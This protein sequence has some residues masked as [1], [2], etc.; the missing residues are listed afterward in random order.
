MIGRSLGVVTLLAFLAGASSFEAAGQTAGGV[1]ADRSAALRRGDAPAVDAIAK[2]RPVLETAPG[3]EVAPTS[4]PLHPWSGGVSWTLEDPSA[5]RQKVVARKLAMEELQVPFDPDTGELTT[6]GRVIVKFADSTGI[7]V[8]NGILPFPISTTGADLT[9]LEWILTG[10]GATARQWIDRDASELATLS[11]RAFRASGRPQPDL[12]TILAIEPSLDSLAMVAQSLNKLDIVEWVEIERTM[13]QAQECPGCGVCDWPCNL[14]SGPTCA[15]NPLG[16]LCQVVQ[17]PECRHGCADALCCN[18]VAAILPACDDPAQPRGWDQL[19]AALANVLCEGTLYDTLNPGLDFPDRYD[20]CLGVVD[21]QGAYVPNP[22]FDPFRELLSGDCFTVRP[23]TIGGSGPWGRGCNQP[24]CCR[25]VCELDPGCCVL[26]WD[27]LCVQIAMQTEPCVLD[28]S[29]KSSANFRPTPNYAAELVLVPENTVFG[30]RNVERARGLQAYTVGA[31]VI[32]WE[33]F[34]ELPPIPSSPEDPLGFLRSGFRGWGLDLPQMRA[35]ASL[36]PPVSGTTGLLLDG[37][38]VRV[39]ILDV[40]FD[41]LHEDFI[42]REQDSGDPFGRCIDPY[43]IPRVILEPGV[44]QLNVLDQ[45]RGHGTAVA[46]MILAG[47]NGFGVTGIASRAQGY[48]FPIASQE[49]GF[50]FQNAFFSMLQEF[51]AGDVAVFP[52]ALAPNGTVGPFARSSQP[53]VTSPAY[54]TLVRIASDLNILCVVSAGNSCAPV[55]EEAAGEPPIRSGALVVGAGYPGA[56]LEVAPAG[57]CIGLGTPGSFSRVVYSNWHGADSAIA[58]VDLFGWGAA[59]ATTGGLPNLFRGV[60][61]EGSPWSR[62]YTNSFGGTSAAAALVAGGAAVLQA[63]GRQTYG[64][65]LRPESIGGLMRDNG[66]PQAGRGY[67]NLFGFPGSDVDCFPDWNLGD[68]VRRIGAGD[69]NRG[70][71]PQLVP[72]AQSLISTG[73]ACALVGLDPTEIAAPIDG[74]EEVEVTVSLTGGNFDGI[75]CGWTATA[76]DSWIVVTVGS[77]TG[78]EGE[79]IVV[80]DVLPNDTDEVRVGEVLIAA[81]SQIGVVTV[82]QAACQL[83]GAVPQEFASNADGGEDLEIAVLMNGQACP[84]TATTAAPWISITVGSGTGAPDGNRVIFDILPNDTTDEREGL[85]LLAGGGG[86]PIEIQVVQTP[87]ASLVA[88]EEDEFQILPSGEVDRTALVI[89]SVGF[90]P[91]VATTQSLWIVITTSAGTGEPGGDQLVF[92]VLPNLTGADRDGTIIV[93]SGAT[94]IEVAVVQAPVDS[95]VVGYTI[96]TGAELTPPDPDRI[97]GIDEIAIDIAAANF[98]GGAPV[99]GLQYI[100]TGWVTDIEVEV[101]YDGFNPGLPGGNVIGLLITNVVSVSIPN[102]IGIAYAFNR[103]TETWDFIA[104]QNPLPQQLQQIGYPL[105]FGS[106]GAYVD[107]LTGL[108]RVRLWTL[109]FSGSIYLVRHDFIN[110]GQNLFLPVP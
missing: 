77:G 55:A 54:Y 96:W 29:P 44:T 75:L 30:V 17:P 84:W 34:V 38:G 102:A 16:P 25:N 26:G 4:P 97:R 51:E 1:A 31:P 79:D 94:E 91:W 48:F 61:A 106:P 23:G 88:V 109:G 82:T 105:N 8:P 28:P 80:F 78:R 90:C 87:C 19:C 21:P 9:D 85:I 64:A 67:G 108:V 66:L 22:V 33:R 12:A 15:A 58:V 76:S 39:G 59:V 93:R 27:I 45:V 10:F 20:P 99:A 69:G 3:A 43:K 86:E 74:I 83:L 101:E 110:A 92:S 71:F 57:S 98:T 81:G 32:G 14:P 6:T 107:P 52:V 63:F 103:T 2:V 60:P 24:E 5:P 95:A 42:C 104:Q 7:R 35:F 13:V 11:E 36:V 41:P 37:E 47:D 18:L 73:L 53:I 49:Q 46:G 56:F 70:V 62:E 72:A 100:A 65:N 68:Q 89:S 50:R 40:A